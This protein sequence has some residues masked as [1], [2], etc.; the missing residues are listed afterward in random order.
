MKNFKMFALILIAS[1]G[2][3]SPEMVAQQRNGRDRDM[4]CLYQDIHYQGWEQCYAAGDEIVDLRGRGNAV[5]SIRIFGRARVIVFD[6]SQFRGTSDEFFNDVPD[7]D[8]RMMNGS[9]SWNDRIGSL[10]VA[11]GYAGPV[12]YPQPNP[13][14]NPYPGN[15]DRDRNYDP[16]E[17]DAICVFQD[18]NF[19][20]RSECFEAGIDVRDLNR[21]A[22]WN[23]RISSIRIIGRAR[24]IF[25]ENSAFRGERLVV[26]RDFSD[27]AI[28]RLRDGSNWNDQISSFE[29]REDPGRGR[30]LARGRPRW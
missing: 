20:G 10:R 17:R 15:R 11:M 26:D 4:V 6:D 13:Y 21:V 24:A 9:R 12:R 28:L 22:G 29:V 7:L 1:L 14:P 25:Y 3:I 19:R 8:R 16:I 18:A 2:Y 30:G 27:L 5:S 23:D